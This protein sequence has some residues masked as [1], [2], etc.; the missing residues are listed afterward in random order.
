MRTPRPTLKPLGSIAQDSSSD[1]VEEM[2][3]WTVDA[4]EM[5]ERKTA[6]QN[7]DHRAVDEAARTTYSFPCCR[8]R[9]VGPG[10][11]RSRDARAYNFAFPERDSD[12]CPAASDIVAQAPHPC[13]QLKKGADIGIP[14]PRPSSWGRVVD[15]S[16]W[17]LPVRRHVWAQCNF[18]SR[19]RA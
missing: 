13:P 3:C 2:R 17:L 11:Q 14:D 19:A 7:V 18:R 4:V 10:I 1:V 5:E 8:S 16:S 12:A 9:V 6:S 15:R